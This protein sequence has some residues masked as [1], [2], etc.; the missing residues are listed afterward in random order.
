M[1]NTIILK[2]LEKKTWAGVVRYK[3]CKDGIDPY[4]DST[5]S[6]K[7]GLTKEDAERLG[8]ILGQDLSPYS[9]FWINFRVL[10]GDKERLFNL[11]NPEHELAYKFML[12]HKRV[13]N[14]LEELPQFPYADYVLINEENEAK[15]MNV[16]FKK[17]REAAKKFD[18]LSP[19]EMRDILKL[20]PSNVYISEGVSN[21]IIESKL[22]ENMKDDPELFL[23]LV[24]DPSRSTKTFVKD[25]TANRILRKNKTAYY[26]GEDMLGHDLD[27]TVGFLDS[28]ANSSLKASLKQ[29]LQ[30]SKK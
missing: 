4:F 28:P 14:S 15:T 1:S 27:S 23:S 9:K 10:M 5:G 2:P 6:V 3:N 7:T 16:S 13:A 24:N 8:S 26:Y 19:N 17:E 30:E 29:A 25:L 21:E 20:Y 12:S 22:Y 11:D 18:T